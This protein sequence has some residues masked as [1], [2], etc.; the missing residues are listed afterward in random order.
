VGGRDVHLNGFPESGIM[1]SQTHSVMA[2][3]KGVRTV[4][5]KMLQATEAAP[6]VRNL[7]PGR[8]TQQQ[9]MQDR[10]DHGLNNQKVTFEADSAVLTQTS[11]KAMGKGI[12]GWRLSAHAFGSVTARIQ[13]AQ[14]RRSNLMIDLVVKAR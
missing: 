9:N 6:Q 12:A 2:E 1:S 10:I 5:S 4:R 3:V 13:P 14:G 8:T 11:Q 7:D